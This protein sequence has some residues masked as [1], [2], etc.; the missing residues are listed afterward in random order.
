MV[1]SLQMD[2]TYIYSWGSWCREGVLS[3]CSCHRFRLQASPVLCACFG[4]VFVQEHLARG[5]R[6]TPETSVCL[7][8]SSYS[9]LNAV[10]GL[11][12]VF[13]NAVG[14]EALFKT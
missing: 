7:E 3:F 10:L 8:S 13:G 5:G 9:V 1:H 11:D 12:Y 14:V 4:G 6:K 2:W